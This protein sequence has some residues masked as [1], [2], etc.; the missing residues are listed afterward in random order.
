[1]EISWTQAFKSNDE[2]ASKHYMWKILGVYSSKGASV[3][4]YTK[5]L[6]RSYTVP[7]KY[8]V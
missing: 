6:G 3:L 2:E 7:L 4:N 5:I 8:S 1:M